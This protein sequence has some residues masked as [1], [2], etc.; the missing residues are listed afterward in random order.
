MT[1]DRLSE[2]G[3]KKEGAKSS[4]CFSEHE[5]TCENDVLSNSGDKEM[6]ELAEV[7]E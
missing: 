7:G 2:R 5:V 1:T 4:P 3:K 6:K